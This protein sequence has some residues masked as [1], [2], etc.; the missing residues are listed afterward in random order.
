MEECQKRELQLYFRDHDRARQTSCRYM[1]RCLPRTPYHRTHHLTRGGSSS[2][3]V[4][5][6]AGRGRTTHRLRGGRRQEQHQSA[7]A[8]LLPEQR[9]L[10]RLVPPG[11]CQASRFLLWCVHP[12]R[13]ALLHLALN[14]PCV[15]SSSGRGPRC[16]GWFADYI[17]QKSDGQ[18]TSLT[19]DGGIKGWVKAGDSYTQTMEGYDAGYWTQFK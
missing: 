2:S 4:P 6:L 5:R 9:R 16:A 14:Y 3:L 19:L 18:M 8:F 11:T 17:A 7:C 12:L 1:V 10:V 15:G 13:N